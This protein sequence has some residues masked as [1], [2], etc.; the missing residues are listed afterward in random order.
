MRTLNASGVRQSSIRPAV[1]L[2]Q[3][4]AHLHDVERVAAGIVSEPLERRRAFH[5]R[6]QGNDGRP[7]LAAVRGFENAG[8]L[9]RRTE[10]EK[11]LSALA[12]DRTERAVLHV[13]QSLPGLTLVGGREYGAVDEPIE[14]VLVPARQG[15][16]AVVRA[17]VERLARVGGPEQTRPAN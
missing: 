2:V 5:L 11:M 7:R 9:E 17:A 6:G 15:P 16:R 12:E 3:L 13:A 14:L 1:P 8:G 10:H 4:G